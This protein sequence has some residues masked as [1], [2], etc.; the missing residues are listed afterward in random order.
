MLFCCLRRYVDASC[1]T[2]RRRL[3]PSTNS[4]AYQ[5]LVSSTRHGPSQL[6][7]LHLA[8]GAFTARDGAI[9]WLRIAISAY[10]HSTP[11]LGGGSRRSIITP[12]SLEKPEWFGYPMVKKKFE[13]MFIRF[14]RIHERDGRTHRQTPHDGIGRACIA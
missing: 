9:Y 5:R 12:F 2:L 7:V 10:L 11:P 14:D 13:D 6:S 1:H 8:L 3:P 4:T